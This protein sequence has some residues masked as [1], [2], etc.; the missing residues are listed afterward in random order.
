[1]KAMT[2]KMY[3]AHCLFQSA[4][5]VC[6]ADLEMPYAFFGLLGDNLIF[7]DHIHI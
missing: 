7:G 4:L 3:S 1:M 5:C 2:L 6:D